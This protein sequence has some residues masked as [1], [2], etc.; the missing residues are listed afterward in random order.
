MPIRK[1]KRKHK[2]NPRKRTKKDNQSKEGQREEG[3]DKKQTKYASISEIEDLGFFPPTYIE[4]AEYDCLHDEGIE[5]GEKLKSQGVPVEVH[6]MKGTCHGYETA[7]KSLI[8]EKCMLRRAEWIR[9][10][11]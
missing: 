6:D 1:G 3:Q 10:I 8:V 7:T 2:H 9:N 4:A 5:F 11:L